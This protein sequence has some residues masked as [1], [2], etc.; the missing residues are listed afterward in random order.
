MDTA[1]GNPGHTSI[2]LSILLAGILLLSGCNYFTIGQDDIDLATKHLDAGAVTSRDIRVMKNFYKSLIAGG[3]LIYP[4]AAAILKH[5]LFGDGSD[6]RLESRYFFNS[7]TVQRAISNMI[8]S[9]SPPVYL[10]I[11]EDPRIAYAVNGFHIEIREGEYYVVQFIDF[12]NTAGG[13]LYTTFPRPGGEL[14]VPDRLVRIFEAEG[15][16]LPFTV[17]IGGH[18]GLPA[19]GEEK[20]R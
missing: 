3:R 14:K 20:N 7:D 5:Y 15:G 10:R 19:A 12:D 16:C 2:K 9:H 1:T 18:Y 6:I 11:S 8:G 13:N 17:Y 4:E